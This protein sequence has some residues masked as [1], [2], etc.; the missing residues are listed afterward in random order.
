MHDGDRILINPSLVNTTNHGHDVAAAK[1]GL[2]KV[3]LP[4][5]GA[6]QEMRGVEGGP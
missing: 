5:R 1:M 6:V 2:A 4:L 3:T